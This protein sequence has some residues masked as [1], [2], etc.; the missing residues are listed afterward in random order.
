MPP[1]TPQN[2]KSNEALLAALM[3]TT[4]DRIYFKDLESKFL[5]ASQ[6]FMEFHN[7]KDIDHLCGKTDFNLFHPNHAQTA[8]MAEQEIIQTG[9]PKVGMVE[10]LPLPNGRTEWALST[11]VPLK[12]D[13]G[14]I[15]G[16][17]GISR[18]ITELHEKEQKII[19]YAETLT[20]RQQEL[21]EQLLLAREVQNA[22]LPDRFPLFGSAANEKD[23]TL[24][25]EH[26]YLPIG[27]VG[28]DFFS[29][30]KLSENKAGVLISDVMGHGVHA[31]LITG[32]QRVLVEDLHHLAHDPGNFL[33]ELNQR[34]CTILAPISTPIFVTACYLTIE[35]TE[36]KVVFSNAA[37]PLPIHLH[38]QSGDIAL[39]DGKT[40]EGIFPLGMAD[41]SSYSNS[42][43]SMHPEDTILLYTDGLTD[44]E[45][46]DEQP[47]MTSDL[48]EIIRT[49][50]TSNQTPLLDQITD[51][52]V[53]HSK[54]QQFADDVC[55]LSVKYLSA[56][57]YS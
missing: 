23:S 56:K 13:Q 18:D 30:T 22:L 49:I 24:Q 45:V 9:K 19:E 55:I 31:A 54:N 40:H 53:S 38:E 35:L 41:S 5:T 42:E 29:I 12:N 4:P 15:I 34:L 7:I 14:E 11:K 27:S 8:L 16:T 44:I 20:R 26:K 33:T 10:E 47:F 2:Q 17:F 25:F 1:L 28:G 57:D 21:D 37:H 46:D 39:I 6:A 3:E 32:I 51:Q 52:I 36:G 50:K 48:L 43:F